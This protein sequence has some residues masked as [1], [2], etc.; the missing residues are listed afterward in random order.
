M[1]EAGVDAH[2]GHHDA[3]AVRADNAHEVRTGGIQR[4]LEKLLALCRA[5]LSEP[6]GNHDGGLGAALPQ[7]RNQAWNRIGGGADDREIRW[8]GQILHRIVGQGRLDG[9]LARVHRH[10]RAGKP[11][12]ERIVR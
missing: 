6:C 7:F 11:G 12:V 8:D 9:L 2:A 5:A 4:C 1:A 3:E 10:D